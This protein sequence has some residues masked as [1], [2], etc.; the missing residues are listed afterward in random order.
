M[1]GM[2]E[3]KKRGLGWIQERKEGRDDEMKRK[4][5]GMDERKKVDQG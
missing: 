1:E 5:V 4:G 2:D 3:R